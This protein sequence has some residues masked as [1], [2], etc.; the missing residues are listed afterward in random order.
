V[1]NLRGRHSPYGAADSRG[2]GAS[3]KESNRVAASSTWMIAMM[4]VLQA[5][6]I[7]IADPGIRENSG[8]AGTYESIN[9]RTM[10]DVWNSC[11]HTEELL[12]LMMR[13]E[14]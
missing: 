6:P 10:I 1:D 5:A 8:K 13:R 2:A 7:T 9:C 12:R 14:N 11:C 4:S 3:S